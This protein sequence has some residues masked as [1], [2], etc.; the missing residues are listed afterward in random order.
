MEEKQWL[1]GEEEEPSCRR[2]SMSEDVHGA[3]AFR[4]LSTIQ[5]GWGSQV[6]GG[7]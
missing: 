2:T 4:E 3:G 7:A 6:D 5:C 1:A